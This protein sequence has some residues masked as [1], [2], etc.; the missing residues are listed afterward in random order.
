MHESCR[1]HHQHTDDE[2]PGLWGW[3]AVRGLDAGVILGLLDD[4]D[5]NKYF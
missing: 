5:R 4:V 3:F 1:L 2:H